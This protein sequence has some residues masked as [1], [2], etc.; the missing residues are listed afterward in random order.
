ME[1]NIRELSPDEMKY[2]S[3]GAG[4]DE[5]PTWKMAYQCR[6]CGFTTYDDYAALLA[7]IKTRHQ[8]SD[9]PSE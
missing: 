2:I 8:D 6:A 1:E 9:F 3:G 4:E 5:Q 7:H